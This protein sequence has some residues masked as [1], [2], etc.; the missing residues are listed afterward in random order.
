MF[1]VGF[2]ELLL[3]GVIALVVIGPERLPQ[4]ARQAGRMMGKVN[5]FISNFKDDINAEAKAEELKK[6]LASQAEALG[7]HEIIEDTKD[8]VNTAKEDAEK[9][10]EEIQQD[11]SEEDLAQ[12][13]ADG[14]VDGMSED[15]TVDEDMF[16]NAESSA[17]KHS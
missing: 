6:T 10:M 15:L 17:E 7:I 8:V 13:E 2:W 11:A 14:L 5:G 9:S 4:V 16:E 1:D 3:I 12:L